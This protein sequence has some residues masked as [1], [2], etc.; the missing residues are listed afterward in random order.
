MSWYKE[1]QYVPSASVK[2][3]A[4]T[5]R[6]QKVTIGPSTVSLDEAAYQLNEARITK[7]EGIRK[8]LNNIADAG[9]VLD[10]DG[11]GNISINIPESSTEQT[12]QDDT[13]DI[14]MSAFEFGGLR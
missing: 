7:M 6:R 2:I 11:Q 14:P 10:I 4:G 3:D 13:V 12:E 1:S 8:I 5:M 9:I